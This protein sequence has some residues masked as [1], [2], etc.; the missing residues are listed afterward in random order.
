VDHPDPLVGL[1]DRNLAR[2]LVGEPAVV[3]V[4]E[5]Q[6]RAPRLANRSVAGGRAPGVLLADDPDPAGVAVEDRRCVVG[7]AVV[8]DEDLDLARVALREDAL[9]RARQELRPVVGRDR[10][11]D[12]QASTSS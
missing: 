2:E 12:R 4:E 10:G 8:D 3:R 6:V 11:R 9:E 7:R 1:E 5:G